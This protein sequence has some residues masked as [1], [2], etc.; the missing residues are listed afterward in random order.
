MRWWKKVKFWKRRD[1]KA[2]LQKHIEELHKQ[3]EEREANQEQSEAIL[4]GRVKELE[5][6][7]EQQIIDREQGEAKLRG[8][9]RELEEELKERDERLCTDAEVIV[10]LKKNLQLEAT[11]REESDR[12]KDVVNGLR[13]ELEEK[14]RVVRELEATI[15]LQNTNTDKEE[16]E[17]DIRNEMEN[18]KMQLQ[19]CKSYYVGTVGSLDIEINTLKKN[20]QER[21]RDMRELETTLHRRCQ[22]IRVERERVNRFNKELSRLQKTNRNNKQVLAALKEL[23]ETLQDANNEKAEVESALLGKMKN[24]VAVV[25]AVAVSLLVVA[26]FF[27]N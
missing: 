15:Q 14:D 6:G 19:N 2:D 1:V 20:L 3:L 17:S 9:I 5:K 18:Y 16:T 7:L 22:D 11:R 4:R 27:I 26:F 21:K 13:K 24:P 25:F 12:V 8:R 23:G 10:E